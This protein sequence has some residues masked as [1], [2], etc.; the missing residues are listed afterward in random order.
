MSPLRTPDSFSK[1][2]GSVGDAEEVVAQERC[3]SMRMS[4]P[5]PP[6]PLDVVSTPPRTSK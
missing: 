3:V 1:D 4:F 2:G 5:L 6:L